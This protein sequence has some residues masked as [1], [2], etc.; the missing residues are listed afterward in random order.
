MDKVDYAYKPLHIG[1][2]SMHDLLVITAA[3][4]QDARVWVATSDDIP[5]LATEAASLE[6][7]IQRVEDVAPELIEDNVPMLG[8]ASDRL[9]ED[10]RIPQTLRVTVRKLLPGERFNDNRISRQGPIPSLVFRQLST[11][12][13]KYYF[14]L[15]LD[16]LFLRVSM[17]RRNQALVQCR[18]VYRHTCMQYMYII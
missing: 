17:F 2:D 16:A 9:I 3:W 15:C 7:L 11:G 14:D 6:D 1:R 10:G 5:G 8:D 12:I 13:A 18:C 4:D